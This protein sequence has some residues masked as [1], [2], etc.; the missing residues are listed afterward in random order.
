MR[1][2]NRFLPGALALLLL[3]TGCS[4]GPSGGDTTERGTESRV[5][6]VTSDDPLVPDV[7][8]LDSYVTFETAKGT[9]IAPV[10]D[11]QGAMVR[12]VLSKETIRT[13]LQTVA[14]CGYTRVYMVVPG[15]GYP[16][17]SGTRCSAPI[18]GRD[19]Q[20][21]ANLLRC[22]GNILKLYVS[23]G[24][25]LGLEMIAVYK[26][27]EGGG[28][29]TVPEGQTA[30]GGNYYEE[31]PGGRRT[32][33]DTFITEHPEMRLVRRDN[34]HL[35]DD[36]PVTMIEAVFML[37]AVRD[38]DQTGT[39][40]S[41][42]AK[43]AEQIGTPE[44][45]LY[46]STDNYLYERY[47]GAFR[48]AWTQ[49]VR[50]VYDANGLL[51]YANANVYVLRV[52]G[53]ALTE[54]TDYITLTFP[55]ADRLNLLTLPYS[56]IS[57]WSGD[58]RL[59]TGVATDARRLMDNDVF[60]DPRGEH[61]WGYENEPA[62]TGRYPFA[63]FL[64]WFTGFGWEF[65]YAGTGIDGEGWQQGY[66]YCVTKGKPQYMAGTLCEGYAEVRAHWMD[67]VKYLSDRC[68]FDGVEIRL[69]GHSSF[70][71]DPIS[72]GYNEPIVSRYR[73]LYGVDISDLSVPVTEEMYVRMMKIRGDYLML[74]LREASDYLHSRQ[75]VFFMHLTEAYSEESRWNLDCYS[76][77]TLCSPYR[78]KVLP[79]WK[80]CI[81]ISDEIS[82]KDYSYG[83]YNAKRAM[84][85]K[86]YAH[87][88]GKTV[89]MHVYYFVDEA[90]YRFL[91]KVDSDPYAG[92]MLWYEYSASRQEETYQGLIDKIGFSKVTHQ[93]QS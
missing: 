81:D 35:T 28:G 48:T 68:G 51:R 76:F 36:S 56:M 1:T 23:E 4:T 31:V 6:P 18:Q 30:D 15:D 62:R 89:W 24:Q 73:E 58:S 47:E 53:F 61:T 80:A 75:K 79:D 5:I 29:L 9:Q 93:K 63:K 10:F 2:V 45:T 88:Q 32:Y 65:E 52:T 92:G 90:T 70:A 22:G 83:A 25:R 13:E 8:S 72:Y 17:F 41:Y 84:K 85:I 26:P 78:P 82:I 12:E 34:A 69:L 39:P 21:A 46:T 55:E 86:Q 74:F 20:L 33:F 50:D 66:A 14:D 71:T 60:G 54:G 57:L 27:Y 3:L 43:T 19:G 59:V 7:P 49:E 77:N 16:V 11:I 44:V 40:V 38:R 67:Y 64:E 91:S 42:R 87:A 37:D